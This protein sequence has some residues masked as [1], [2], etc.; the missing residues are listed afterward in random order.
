MKTD[1]I[2]NL[3]LLLLLLS[4]ICSCK[5]LK[6]N[7]LKEY[8]SV[9]KFKRDTL[10]ANYIEY[11]T[12]NYPLIITVP[13]GGRLTVD[14]MV[15]RTKENCPDEQFWN[16]YDEHTPELGDLID[17]IVFARTGKYPYLVIPQ[18][19]RK[20]IDMNRPLEF[21]VPFLNKSSEIVYN[22]FHNFISEA[23]KSITQSYGA[24]LLLDIHAHGHKIHRIELGYQL[25]DSVINLSDGLLD[26]H[27]HDKESSIHNLS[28]KVKDSQ[29]FSQ[30]LRGNNSFGT[31]L[32]SY[33]IECIPNKW[34]PSPGNAS[35]FNGGYV[36]RFH[37]SRDGGSID[38]IQLEFDP[39]SRKVPA[40]RKNTATMIVMTVEQ[41]FKLNYKFDI[42]L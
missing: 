23:K 26:A 13:H 42:N 7:N 32:K 16:S 25:S 19:K 28:Q 35:Y 2:I 1:R 24:G 31:I 4:V 34:S 11:R 12:G 29:S 6:H 41:F 9:E 37:G 36:T 20:Y 21:A 22:Q 39:T 27:G 38:A 3:G 33:G 15:V 40:T 17:S 30:I 5:T 14:S 18:L 10:Y 8:G